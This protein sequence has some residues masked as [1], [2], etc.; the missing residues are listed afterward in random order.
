MSQ[1]ISS[2]SIGRRFEKYKHTSPRKPVECV[3][4]Q[5]DHVD[6]DAHGVWQCAAPYEHAAAIR[7]SRHVKQCRALSLSESHW[8]AL[9]TLS[10]AEAATNTPRILK[11]SNTP[12]RIAQKTYRVIQKLLE[13]S[14]SVCREHSA[15]SCQ[16]RARQTRDRGKGARER[17]SVWCMVRSHHRETSQHRSVKSFT[18][19][20]HLRAVAYS[21]QSDI[22][23]IEGICLRHSTRD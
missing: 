17:A 16:R 13:S 9:G 6:R 23:D 2:W 5:S 21:R 1:E 11:Q 19:S 20:H 12:D 22:P 7:Q 8:A 15:M 4:T 18:S 3:Q 14:R 10:F